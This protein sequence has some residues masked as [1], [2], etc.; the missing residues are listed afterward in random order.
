MYYPVESTITPVTTIRRERL[1]P[2]AGQVLV[3]P[4]EMVGPKYVRKSP[5]DA[6]QANEVIASPKGLLGRLRGGLRSP[7]NG[8]VIDVREGLILIQS[9][10]TTYEL[11]AHLKGQVTN[12]M[13]QRGVVISAVGALIQG[14]WG[15]G[16][17]AEGVLKVLVDNPQRPLRARS[18]DVSCHGT[19]VV[20]GRILDEKALEQGVEAKVRGVVAGSVSAE[21]CPFLESLPYP[22]I[23][24]EGFGALPMSD[25]VFALLHANMGQQAMLGATTLTRWGARRPEILVPLRAED[26]KPPE[27]A[28]PRPLEVGDRVR[29]LR[30]P[31]LGSVG[32]IED[33]LDRPQ[34]IESGARVLAARVDLGDGESV[35]VPL[36]NLEVIR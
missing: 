7:V 6:V 33:L 35:V 16:G 11:T 26:E 19:I 24:T 4:G 29:I 1:L 25:P 8:E 12:V 20:G 18:I 31:H 14:V 15:S 3:R 17:E 27:E 10:S 5:G 21:L 22:V 13:P 36:A 28:R 30:A 34:A 9:A 2:A 32:R 23:I